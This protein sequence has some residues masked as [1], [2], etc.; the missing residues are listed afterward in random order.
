[1]R[2]PVVQSAIALLVFVAVF[3]V[4]LKRSREYF[5]EQELP[6]QAAFNLPAHSPT[7]E[8]DNI[9]K[10]IHQTAPANIDN[11]PDEWHMCQASWQE[12]FPDWQ[13]TL[14][15]DEDIDRFMQEYYPTFYPLFMAY[16]AQIKR[17]DVFRYFV[18]YEIGGL[19]A[20]MDYI[21]YR[22]FE[23]KL[24]VGKVS[25][26]QAFNDVYQNALMASAPKHPFWLYVFVEL[27]TQP[28]HACVIVSTGPDVLLRAANRA[29]NP[30][31]VH[32][33]NMHNF[34]HCEEGTDDCFSRHLETGKWKND[35]WD[36][37]CP[38]S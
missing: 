21:C 1:M 5:M 29:D 13:Y 4:L 16:E 10:I 34:Y 35:G 2:K 33:L 26:N 6:I 23:H 17:V 7:W 14:W 27:M 22:N 32:Q 25:L 20:D 3:L 15:T 30:Q 24:P 28:S 38:Y 19:Y 11:W 18:L 12:K 9:P 37:Q 36:N 31:Y 8:I